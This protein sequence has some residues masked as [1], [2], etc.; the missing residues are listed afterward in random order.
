MSTLTGTVAFFDI[1]GT[2]A[3]V[4]LSPDGDRIADLTVYADVPEVLADLRRRGARVGIVSDPG[5]VPHGEVD[6]ALQ[7]AGLGGLLDP[8][9]VVYGAKDSPRVFEQAVARAGAVDRALFVGED[10]AERAHALAAG[11]LVDR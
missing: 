9:L 6:R 2:L 10:A 11:L 8:D 7:D 5:P 4:T 3:S 1:G